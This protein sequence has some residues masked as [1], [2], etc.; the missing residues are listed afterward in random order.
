MREYVSVYPYSSDTDYLYD[1]I[2]TETAKTNQ[3][4]A[5]S[6]EPQSASTKQPSVNHTTRQ[7]SNT[8]Q[9]NYLTQRPLTPN[10]PS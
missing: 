4:S 6:K 5:V 1:E 7:Q 2:S 3:T 10:I 9:S 8:E